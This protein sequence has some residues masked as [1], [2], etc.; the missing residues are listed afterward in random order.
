LFKSHITQDLYDE[1]LDSFELKK[2]EFTPSPFV[3]VDPTDGFIRVVAGSY[4]NED[5]KGYTTVSVG[6]PGELE[7]ISTAES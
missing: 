3:F 2:K 6:A 7:Y 5:G 4:M 1:F